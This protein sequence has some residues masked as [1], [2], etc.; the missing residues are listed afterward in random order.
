MKIIV[1]NLIVYDRDNP[2]SSW[3]LV[4]DEKVVSAAVGAYYDRTPNI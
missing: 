1:D 4:S 2:D 3:I